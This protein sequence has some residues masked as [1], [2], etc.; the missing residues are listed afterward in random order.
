MIKSESPITI[1]KEVQ[2]VSPYIKIP[3]NI[4]SFQFDSNDIKEGFILVNI[5]YFIFEDIVDKHKIQIDKKNLS[6]FIS[7]VSLYYHNNFFHNFQHAINVLQMTWFLLNETNISLYFQPHIIFALLI[8]ALCHDIDHP[9][10]TNSYEINSMSKR[11][12]IY[13]DIS[14]LENHHC[15]VT[16]DLL[17]KC[18]LNKYFNITEFKE[19][20]KTIITCILSTDMIKHNELMVD[21]LKFDMSKSNFTIDEQIFIAKILLH[22]SDLSNTIK[23]FDTSFNWSKKILLE[24]NV[25]ALKEELEGLPTLSFMKAQDDISM[26]INEINFINTITL[27]MWNM[28]TE[29]IPSLNFINIAIQNNLDNWRNLLDE[30]K[31][32][33]SFDTI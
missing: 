14:V 7:N 1:K 16:F 29:K 17:L 10:N 31:K 30:Y 13:N 4:N 5:A 25:Q 9:G 3:D 11:A 21:F 19:I 22:F 28:F 33:N 26:C 23:K 2:M 12:L 18:E 24:F 15:A 27:P 32:E 6:N 20:R 8:S